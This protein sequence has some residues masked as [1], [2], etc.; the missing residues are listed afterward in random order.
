MVSSKGNAKEMHVMI[1]KTFP[2]NTTYLSTPTDT[3]QEKLDAM[4][5]YAAKNE[6]STQFVTM[7]ELKKNNPNPKVAA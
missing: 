4:K 6:K 3:S 2:A 1:D 5:S 7:S